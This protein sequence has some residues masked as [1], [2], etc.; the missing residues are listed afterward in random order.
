MTARGVCRLVP[1]Q[2]YDLHRWYSMSREKNSILIYEHKMNRVTLPLRRKHLSLLFHLIQFVKLWRIFLKLN[3]KW[4][5][6]SSDRREVKSLSFVHVLH[7]TRYKKFHV[8][9][10]QW[11]Q[12]NVEK[13]VMGLDCCCFANLNLLLFWCPRCRLR[14]RC[15]VSSLIP[16]QWKSS[17]STTEESYT[18]SLG[19]NAHYT[20]RRWMD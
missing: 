12:G 14:L 13:S 16:R 20:P 7:K 3:S 18:I 15:L 2:H 1:W 9:V 10:V 4:L 5:Y 19:L 8:V 6:L 17:K 11:R